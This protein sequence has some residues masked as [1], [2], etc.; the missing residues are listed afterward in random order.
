MSEEKK[1]DPFITWNDSDQG[2]KAR[3]F[4]NFSDALDSYDGISKGYHRD[5]LDIEPNRSVRPQFGASDY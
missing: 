2:S 1:E 3:A 4:D 5:F